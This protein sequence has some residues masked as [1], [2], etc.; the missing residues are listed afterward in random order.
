M[1]GKKG[2]GFVNDPKKA[3]YNK[4]Y[5]KSTSKINNSIDDIFIKTCSIFFGIFVL[6]LLSILIIVLIFIFSVLF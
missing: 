4:V 2:M 5:N 3:V 6:M 1:Y